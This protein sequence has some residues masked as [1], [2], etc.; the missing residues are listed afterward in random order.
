M[1]FANRKEAI[2]RVLF[3]LLF[4]GLAHPVAAQ[5]DAYPNRPI[6]IMVTVPPGGAADF[7]ARTVGAKLSEAVGQPVLVENRAGASGTIAADA[8]AK[9]PPDGYTLLQNSFTT[10]GVAPLIYSKLPYDSFRDLAP[11]TLL[12]QIP[13][14]MAVNA[15]VPAKSAEEFIALAKSKPGAFSF[16]SSGS[17]G[18]PHLT[19]ELFKS[20]TGADLVHVPYK[21][22]GPA[23]TDLI[24][25]RVQVMFDGAP[26]L[27]AHV[28]SGKLRVLAAA[29]RKRNPLAPDA[30]TFAEIG[31]PQIDVSL[32]YGVM[33]PAGTP[34]PVIDRLNREIGKVLALPEIRER[35]AAQGAEATPTTPE[36]FAQF[37]RRELAKWAPVVKKA[38]VKAD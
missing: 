4:L 19:G 5:T 9:A 26:S 11:V 23:V 7:I 13:L 36:Q 33:V 14:I 10:H 6:R 35:F 12:T 16:C 34:K 20:E 32:W 18:A 31:Y 8:V 29:G 1:I 30:P 21:G 24:A 38:G 15:E 27:L 2:V 17:G 3:A 28:K 37:M 25:G 22:S